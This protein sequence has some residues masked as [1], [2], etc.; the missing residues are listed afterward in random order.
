MNSID[1]KSTS[2]NRKKFF[3]SLGTGLAGFIA[4]SAFPFNIFSNKNKKVKIEINPY[5]VSR[6]KAGEKNA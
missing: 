5:A 2:M 3:A 1:K 4:A 6:K